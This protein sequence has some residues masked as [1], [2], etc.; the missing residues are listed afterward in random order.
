M[1]WAQVGI[2]KIKSDLNYAK[3]KEASITNSLF[4]RGFYHAFDSE[5]KLKRNNIRPPKSWIVCSVMSDE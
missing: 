2:L 4:K 1:D 3:Q 5:R